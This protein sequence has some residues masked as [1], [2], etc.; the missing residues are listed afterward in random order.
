MAVRLIQNDFNCQNFIFKKD[1]EFNFLTSV[2][3]LLIQ[4]RPQ[5]NINNYCF[6]KK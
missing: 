6:Q 1:N 3:L 2:S 4:A 5:Y